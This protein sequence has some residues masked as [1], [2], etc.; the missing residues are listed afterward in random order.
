MPTIGRHNFEDCNGV[1]SIA[2]QRYSKCGDCTNNPPLKQLVLTHKTPK[3]LER[4]NYQ[5][6]LYGCRAS[7]NVSMNDL[8]PFINYQLSPLFRFKK[9]RVA[10]RIF[11]KTTRCISA[12][13]ILTRIQIKRVSIILPIYS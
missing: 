6:N 11:L 9:S 7:I 10:S 8:A 3:E 5:M 4:I 13:L 2:R 12:V 1:E